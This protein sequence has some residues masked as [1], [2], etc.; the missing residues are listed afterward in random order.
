MAPT[1]LFLAMSIVI[2]LGLCL[3]ASAD[4]SSKPGSSGTTGSDS[5]QGSGPGPSGAGCTPVEFT[6]RAV[7]DV[8]FAGCFPTSAPYP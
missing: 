3:P 2:L 1:P 5:T 8:N 7:P 4:P 6:P